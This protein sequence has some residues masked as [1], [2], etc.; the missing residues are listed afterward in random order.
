MDIPAS[1]VRLMTND[2][3][4]EATRTYVAASEAYNKVLERQQT[5]DDAPTRAEWQAAHETFTTALADYE[6]AMKL[7]L[8][9]GS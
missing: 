9:G 2:E 7:W 1:M 6:A 5:D 4:R 3:A 8:P